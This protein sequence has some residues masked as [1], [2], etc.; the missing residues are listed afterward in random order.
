[1]SNQKF[2][3]AMALALGLGISGQAH[4]WMQY[5]NGTSLTLWTTYQWY[6]PS[7]DPTGGNP[8]QKQG[9]WSLNPGECKIVFGASLPGRYSYYYAEGGGQVWAGAYSTCTP[10]SAFNYCDN[11]CNTNARSLGY[12]EL[13]T[14][15]STN[16]TLTFTP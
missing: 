1:M 8:W 13:D 10:Y 2:A 15:T 12:R 3:A 9:W 7:C 14:G 11:L 4:A 16:Y 5:C 6:A